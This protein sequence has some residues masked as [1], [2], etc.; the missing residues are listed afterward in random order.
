MLK[1][2]SKAIIISLA[3]SSCVS[4]GQQLEDGAIAAEDSA[5]ADENVEAITDAD[6]ETVLSESAP[7]YKYQR[8]IGNGY[9]AGLIGESDPDWN[10]FSGKEFDSLQELVHDGRLSRCITSDDGSPFSSSDIVPEEKWR[11]RREVL[12]TI[13]QRRNLPR[14]EK[15]L[16]LASIRKS[17]DLLEKITEFQQV[18]DAAD[19]ERIKELIKQS[20]PYENA[21]GLILAVKTG[22]VD[23]IHLFLS[24][25]VDCNVLNLG[26][27]SALVVA[28]EQ[29][30]LQV[31]SVLLEHG[32]DAN[33]GKNWWGTPLDNANTNKRYIESKPNT[34]LIKLL[35]K[36]GAK[37][38]RN[39]FL[40]A[41]SRG[42]FESIKLFA[43][44]GYNPNEK[45]DVNE[46]SDAISCLIS[47]YC[48]HP[49]KF[50]VSF[51]AV[52]EYMV[53]HG[54]NINSTFDV[55]NP[56]TPLQYAIEEYCRYDEPSGVDYSKEKNRMAE[57]VDVLLAHGASMSI[58][59][60]NGE[61]LALLAEGNEKI[62][63]LLKHYG[64]KSVELWNGFTDGMTM[65]QVI[66]RADKLLNAKAVH[67]FVD[68]YAETYG[69]PEVFHQKRELNIVVVPDSIVAYKSPNTEFFT[70]VPNNNV[71]FYFYKNTLYAVAI[72]WNYNAVNQ[73]IKMAFEKFGKNYDFFEEQSSTENA[74]YSTGIARWK[75]NDKTVY[76][77]G[78][79]RYGYYQSFTT[80]DDC[81]S[82]V[83]FSQPIVKRYEHDLRIEKAK[84]AMQSA[85]AQRNLESRIK[86]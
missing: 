21:E 4:T 39:P 13:I 24:E 23:T 5:V 36:K 45:K 60:D 38:D 30:D 12:E 35:L 31:A 83:V 86:L 16:E 64:Y 11:L 44:Y 84:N 26:G 10:V 3:L 62:L 50:S 81:V 19:K 18:V 75:K 20:C 22:N 1:L 7:K 57:A 15:I 73:I 29:N 28:C 14:K 55:S 37:A 68:S 79:T 32:A 40:E 8:Y 66:A 2:I 48:N 70:D 34:G 51:S 82:T 9:F 85:E 74:A 77:I 27:E 42:D 52:V 33:V 76:L 6:I 41:C 46:D 54:A 25:G 69:A 61:T 72:Q 49:E 58:Q 71:C 65:D 59:N 47:A 56:K 67:L 53:K 63:S 17:V 43:E 80:K 78:E